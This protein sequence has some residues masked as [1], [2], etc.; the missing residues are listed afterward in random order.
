M[1]TGAVWRL[2][3]EHIDIVK[4]ANCG[5]ELAW[6]LC[7][8]EHVKNPVQIRGHLA[9][10]ARTACTSALA[11]LHARAEALDARPETLSDFAAYQAPA[12]TMLHPA[13]A[14]MMQSPAD[15]QSKTSW[16]RVLMCTCAG[17]DRSD[18]PLD[19]HVWCRLIIRVRQHTPDCVSTHAL[20]LLPTRA[21]S[22][23]QRV[24]L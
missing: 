22:Q 9:A 3:H 16:V 12:C 20:Q 23:V 1:R 7:V 17:C 4:E 10:L 13:H 14:A 5:S 8:H 11:A 19:R 2:L 18:R 24:C 6:H 15:P 21:L